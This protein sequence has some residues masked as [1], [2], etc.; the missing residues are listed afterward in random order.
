MVKGKVKARLLQEHLKP[1]F[2]LPL[3]NLRSILPIAIFAIPEFVVI[4]IN[5]LIAQISIP[6]F[7]VLASPM[8]NTLIMALS[9]CGR[10][11]ISSVAET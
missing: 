10:R 11:R 9:S 2:L 4:V 6:A 3:R 5:V 7:R 1:L 8:N